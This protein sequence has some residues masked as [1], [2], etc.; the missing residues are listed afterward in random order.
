VLTRRN[1]QSVAVE[2]V[3][4]AEGEGEGQAWARSRGENY[5]GGQEGGERRRGKGEY[6][7]VRMEL[8]TKGKDHVYVMD[9]HSM[10]VKQQIMKERH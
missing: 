10:S 5:G 6:A 8:T 9:V 1:R 2:D 3:R 7:C 4:E